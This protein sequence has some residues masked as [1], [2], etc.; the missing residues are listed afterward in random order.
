MSL[1][2]GKYFEA[3]AS[4]IDPD[5]KSIVACFPADAGMDECCFKMEYDI[6]V[7]GVG[8]INNTFGIKG[9]QEHTF[10]FKSITDANK[11]RRQVSECFERAALPNTSDEV[12]L[13]HGAF[14]KQ[15]NTSLHI[16]TECMVVQRYFI[17]AKLLFK[18]VVWWL[19]L[20]TLHNTSAQVMLI[21]AALKSI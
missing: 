7:L 8:S 14:A 3:V 1:L 6:L 18:M 11:L 21:H 13:M 2:Q 17:I 5:K 16:S 19:S 10:F 20:A 15:L 4:D 9:V 12:M